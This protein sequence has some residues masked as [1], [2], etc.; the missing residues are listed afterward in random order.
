MISLASW[1]FTS[2]AVKLSSCG[3]NRHFP[4]LLWW[5]CAFSLLTPSC[6]H[7]QTLQFNGKPLSNSNKQH[8]LLHPTAKVSPVDWNLMTQKVS[9]NISLIYLTGEK[10]GGLFFKNICFL[11]W[12]MFHLRY[13][14]WKI[15]T[16]RD[17]TALAV[18]LFS[19]ENKS[20][21]VNIQETV[22]WN[23]EMLSLKTFIIIGLTVCCSR[24][25]PRSK[26]PMLLAVDVQ[27]R[28]SWYNCRS[29]L[30]NFTL[31]RF[32]YSKCFL[33]LSSK[34]LQRPYAL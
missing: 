8:H 6:T 2:A 24:V 18:I 16:Q 28:E 4:C 34:E 15:F 3:R 23:P 17:A 25:L 9:L 5:S 21:Y 22:L 7:C 13:G 27:G 14:V 26:F 31:H 30:Y 1:L 29:S 33:L 12:A 10:C 32:Q 20:C 19:L 11:C